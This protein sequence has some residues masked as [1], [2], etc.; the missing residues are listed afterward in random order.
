MNMAGKH[1]FFLIWAMGFSGL[2]LINIVL[3]SHS[4]SFEP[5]VS[6]VA[7]D[8]ASH[9]EQPSVP[10]SNSAVLEPVHTSAR[11][12]FVQARRP[13]K[14]PA[15]EVPKSPAKS[16]TTPQQPTSSAVTKNVPD[17]KVSLIGVQ[18]SPHGTRALLARPGR[19]QPE[20]LEIGA[21][22]DN[23]SLV[24]IDDSS[25]RFMAGEKSKIVLLYKDV[26]KVDLE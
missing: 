12:I 9:G 3:A 21:V 7:A 15:V 5:I 4:P 26:P 1:S 2:V 8:R 13:W 24:E 23:W 10:A 6:H 18:R 19:P 11:P 22:L 17:L 25:A 16:A 20:W 14:P